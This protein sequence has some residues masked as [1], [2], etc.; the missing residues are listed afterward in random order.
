MTETSTTWILM[1]DDEP[2][3]LDGYRR[4]LHGRFQLVTA[5]SG[6]DGLAVV[7]HAVELGTPF[8]VVVSDMMMPTMNG[9]EF[10]GQVKKIDP[11]AVQLLLSG[12]AD[13][14]STIDAVNRGNLFRFLTKP[15]GAAELETALIAAVEQH[16][17]VQAERELLERTLF[18]AVGVLTDLLSLSSQEALTRTERVRGL[19]DRAA[20]ELGI[21][22][23]RLPLA[24]MLSQIGCVAVPGDVL[25]RARTGSV[26]DTDELDVYLAHPDTARQLLERIPR[27]EDV[28][29]WVGHQPV[30]PPT[31]PA[32]ATA[33]IGPP[34]EAD[35]ED[36]ELLLRAGLALLAMI[37]ATGHLARAVY[38]LTQTGHFPGPM[39]DALAESAKHLA[40]QGVLRELTVAQMRP[41]MLLDSDIQTVNGLTLVRRG[42]RLTEAA[43]MR[44]ANFARTVGIKEPIYVMTGV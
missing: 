7:K 32:E 17:L 30:R 25:E 3:I 8:S 28:A 43:A 4:A 15:C 44:L 36:A 9:A 2:N 5:N 20:A 31:A 6:A 23:W 33:W 21:T 34:V 16:R 26:L 35:I 40:P 19:V 24:T 27:L 41:G 13:L 18:G 38:L 37:D 39:L 42:E 10:L 22:D 11:D 14:A 1:V 29:A 12:Q